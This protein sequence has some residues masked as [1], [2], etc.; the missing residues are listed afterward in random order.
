MT[1]STNFSPAIGTGG[2]PAGPEDDATE[3]P[4]APAAGDVAA[5]APAAALGALV[6]EAGDALGAD[7]APAAL[8]AGPLLGFKGGS[9]AACLH[10]LDNW[11]LCSLRQATIL[12]PPGC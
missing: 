5:G 4:A 10:P 2:R 12:P 1:R 6:P 8:G 9:P 7:D 11:S 3:P